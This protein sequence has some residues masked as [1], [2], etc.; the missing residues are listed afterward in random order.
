M[1]VVFYEEDNSEVSK[2]KVIKNF[3]FSTYLEE[4]KK[5]FEE[6]IEAFRIGD[7]QKFPKSSQKDG[8]FHIRP[9]ARNSKDTF[10]FTNG[11]QEVRRTFWANKDTV[12]GII[13]SQQN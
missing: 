8:A 10:E 3:N 4:A 6:T 12:L 13:N 1:L 11:E 2:I 7:S 5:A 9:K